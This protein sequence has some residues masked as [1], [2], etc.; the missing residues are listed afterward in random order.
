MAA[1]TD[2]DMLT[3]IRTPISHYDQVEVPASRLKQE[4]C[5][6]LLDEGY[7]KSYGVHRVGVRRD[8]HPA[9]AGPARKV[10]TQPRVSK[11]GLRIYRGK[12]AAARAQQLGSHPEHLPRSDDRR[13]AR[14][15]VWAAK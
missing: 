11:P 15:G 1:I 2:P 8:P 13:E 6:I 3:R 5:R 9:Q 12:R 10:L 7:I 4:I 14:R